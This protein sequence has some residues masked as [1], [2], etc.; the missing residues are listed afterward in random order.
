M[1]YTYDEIG[2]LDSKSKKYLVDNEY[3]G[4]SDWYKGG[5]AEEGGEEE[6]N[7]EGEGEKGGERAGK[8]KQENS[9]TLKKET[10]LIV[11]TFCLWCKIN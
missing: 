2:N 10:T 4:Q 9:S 5:L 7:V 6:E 11:I 1:V 3:P 8:E